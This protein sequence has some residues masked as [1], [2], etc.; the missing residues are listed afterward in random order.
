MVGR[1]F[2]IK[3]AQSWNLTSTYTELLGKIHNTY[4]VLN[5]Y[6]Q[7][8]LARATY[9]CNCVL[10]QLTQT[11]TYFLTGPCHV[12]KTRMYTQ[13]VRTIHSTYAVLGSSQL[14]TLNL[15]VFAYVFSRRPKRSMLTYV[16]AIYRRYNPYRLT[17][18]MIVSAPLS[19]VPGIT[20]MYM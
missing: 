15:R 19:F 9:A 1:S 17:C 2:I 10:L 13:L 7:L 12:L 14:N 6:V 20:V 5:K 18:R 16:T 8:Q 3:A 11:T 4:L